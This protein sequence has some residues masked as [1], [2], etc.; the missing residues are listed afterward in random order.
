MELIFLSEQDL[1]ILDHAYAT[2]DYDI[3]FDALVPQKSSFVVNKQVLNCGIGDLLITRDNGYGYVGIITAIE[4]DDKNR[5]KVKTKDFLSLFD[6][7]VPL[8]TSFSGN[9]AQF[10][11]NLINNTYRYSGDSFQNIS[12][13]E[14]GNRY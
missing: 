2:D 12:Y 14:T 9:I 3:I 13:L 7:D 6:V 1:T 10:V 11:V 4:K 5:N 8:P